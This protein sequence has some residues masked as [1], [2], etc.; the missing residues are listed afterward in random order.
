MSELEYKTFEKMIA[1]EEQSG[2]SIDAVQ[3]D[4]YAGTEQ[5]L[6][7]EDSDADEQD[8]RDNYKKKQ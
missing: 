2:E 5:D 7:G 8:L 3:D 4:H 1:L 6:D